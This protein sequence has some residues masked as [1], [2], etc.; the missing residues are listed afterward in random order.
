MSRRD[1]EGDGV[2]EVGPGAEAPEH[3]LRDRP[4]LRAVVEG[5]HDDAEEEHRRDGSHPEVVDRRQ[6]VL[7]AVGRHAHDLDGAEVGRDERQTRHPRRQ[8]PAGQEE[9]DR[10]G[11]GASGGEP[12]AHDER[13]VQRD[14]E[15]V[16]DV[17]VDERFSSRQ[18]YRCEGRWHQRHPPG[19]RRLREPERRSTYSRRSP[20]RVEAR[21][22]SAV[23]TGQ[24]LRSRRS[25]IQSPSL[26][27]QPEGDAVAAGVSV[28]AGRGTG[29][30]GEVLPR[31]VQQAHA[32]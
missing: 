26:D 24:R 27:E 17:G 11:D 14:D 7:R 31:A 23:G 3:E 8:R 19:R 1:G 30:G 4:H 25:V 22:S 16:D 32:G 21:Q 13:E 18:G 5:H 28:R 12:D 29:A 15:V 10:V 6:A 2:D 20:C 9:V